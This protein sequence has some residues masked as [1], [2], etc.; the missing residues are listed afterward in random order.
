MDY[1]EIT[2]EENEFYIENEYISICPS[3]NEEVMQLISVI[4][5]NYLVFYLI[6]YQREIL[7][8]LK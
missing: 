5:K 4:I 2:L 8:L 3:F 7:V 1:S 6:I